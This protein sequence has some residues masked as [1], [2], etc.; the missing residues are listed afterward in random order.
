M[1][2]VFHDIEAGQLPDELK[3]RGI[4][5]DRR[6]RLVVETIKARLAGGKTESFHFEI[7]V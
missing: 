5:L 3:R 1:K 6:I 4:T 7:A 2:Q